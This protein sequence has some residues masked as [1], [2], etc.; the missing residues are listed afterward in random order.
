MLAQVPDSFEDLISFYRAQIGI[1]IVK[2]L[3]N[4]LDIG[5][6]RD[7]SAYDYMWENSYATIINFIN[8]YRSDTGQDTLTSDEVT[9]ILSG[10]YQKGYK[11]FIDDANLDGKFDVADI[12]ALYNSARMRYYGPLDKRTDGWRTSP[13][14]DWGWTVTVGGKT[15]QQ[16]S[17]YSPNLAFGFVGSSADSGYKF[18]DFAN[19]QRVV[20]T[21][22][23]NTICTSTMSDLCPDICGN[24]QYET[25][26]TLKSNSRSFSLIGFGQRTDIYPNF[27]AELKLTF[28][29]QPATDSY[30][31]LRDYDDNVKSYKFVDSGTTGS[32]LIGGN[33]A[34][35]KQSTLQLTLEELETAVESSGQGISAVVD[36]VA[37]NVNDLVNISFIQGADGEVGNTS[38]IY[39]GNLT[40]SLTE[41]TNR[42][43]GGRKY[44]ST[45]PNTYRGWHEYFWDLYK[46]KSSELY[47]NEVKYGQNG[48]S[49]IPLELRVSSEHK[50]LTE[51]MSFVSW[52][53]T[54]LDFC[55]SYPNISTANAKIKALP[56]EGFS[57]CE[58]FDAIT[59]AKLTAIQAEE[60][61]NFFQVP[62]HGKISILSHN[63]RTE[64]GLEKYGR[65]ANIDNSYRAAPITMDGG[66]LITAKLFI[67]PMPDWEYNKSIKIL[68]SHNDA[69]S[70]SMA[71][72]ASSIQPI[73]EVKEIADT[74]NN[75][76]MV[77]PRTSE[78]SQ[79]YA[80]DSA[81]M[82]TYSDYV[83][84]AQI[85]DPRT[86]IIKYNTTRPF[87]YA[88]F[89]IRAHKGNSEIESVTAP[90]F[91]MY[92][93]YKGWSFT[94]H[95]HE[96]LQQ[97]IDGLPYTPKRYGSDGYSVVTVAPAGQVTT[98]SGTLYGV[99]NPSSFSGMG[100]L[101]VI[102]FKE[103]I[104]GALPIFGKE[105]ICPPIGR[106]NVVYPQ[107]RVDTTI[108]ETAKQIDNKYPEGSRE[109]TKYT[110]ATSSNYE[111]QIVFNYDSANNDDEKM[112][113]DEDKNLQ[114]W[115]SSPF[116]T[117]LVPYLNQVS[118][119]PTYSIEDGEPKYSLFFDKSNGLS[120]PSGALVDDAAITK[121]SAYCAVK[122]HDT[123]INDTTPMTVFV[124]GDT[125]AS[126]APRLSL[127]FE[128]INGTTFN[129]LA[130]IEDGAGTSAFSELSFTA[131]PEEF[132]G[133]HVFSWVGDIDKSTSQLYMDGKLV[134]S[135]ST[136]SGMVPNNTNPQPLDVHIGYNGDE[137]H[138]QVD[139]HSEPFHGKIGQIIMFAEMHDSEYRQKAESYLAIKYDVQQNLPFEHIGY[140][141]ESIANGLTEAGY[142]SLNKTDNLAA[143]ARVLAQ[144]GTSESLRVQD[145]GS[146]RCA[147]AWVSKHICLDKEGQTLIGT[148]CGP[149]TGTTIVSSVS[150]SLT[151]GGSIS[152][153]GISQYNPGGG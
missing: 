81:S 12:V 15:Q 36:A 128:R 54:T 126:A 34:V 11:G 137:T 73:G 71:V 105:Y 143:S 97:N 31:T 102:R 104:C 99:S 67:T 139:A 9:E 112:K 98:N 78:F 121:W 29:Q 27:A 24:M 25:E 48:A 23:Q 123:S 103:D 37:L 30:I 72:F 110:K 135:D 18:E 90:P 148:K 80:Q 120:H 13:T 86:V 117:K 40:D 144:G 55:D 106:N 146:D 114:V 2:A 68:D 61:N 91:S 35:V 83:L 85:I 64:G 14:T 20:P 118:S 129:V 44:Y 32:V 49:F 125:Y 59:G 140:K 46:I 119:A 69:L 39:G 138:A 60:Y 22:C 58:A 19:F 70:E 17:N 94:H 149:N 153:G 56:G 66:K 42:F 133:W 122:L 92:G 96:N 136:M 8:Q 47:R 132:S 84:H 51:A 26:E 53:W 38:V 7:R 111:T 88:S 107:V 152:I 77:G 150:G 116:G 141:H 63:F 16:Y 87:S 6:D 124:V 127:Q 21:Y 100:H 79:N 4:G 41:F 108:D 147:A 43:T 101:C 57:M 82:L 33:I 109:D 131:T 89:S 62:S 45:L 134:A 115:Y 95:F 3:H 151:D 10:F 65:D 75:T 1:Y 52:S 145:L 28:F 93:D 5:Y 113:L 74:T 76:L 130:K 142:L 50:R